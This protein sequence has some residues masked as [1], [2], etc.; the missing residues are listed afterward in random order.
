MTRFLEKIIFLDIFDEKY[1]VRSL[2]KILT[3]KN[4][5]VNY[6]LIDQIAHMYVH[7]P[8]RKLLLE[9]QLD[10]LFYFNR[11]LKYRY[12]NMLPQGPPR[13]SKTMK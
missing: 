12:R 2:A 13:Q 4:T 11:I 3:V 10:R 6:Y 8:V 9:N 1:H 5:W 7:T